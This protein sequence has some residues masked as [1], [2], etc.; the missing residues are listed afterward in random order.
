MEVGGEPGTRGRELG[1]E[2]GK[3]RA[4]S[5]KS[6][7]C[8]GTGSVGICG[9]FTVQAQLAV[10]ICAGESQNELPTLGHESKSPV[11]MFCVRVGE[12]LV[13]RVCFVTKRAPRDRR[14]RERKDP[15][16]EGKEGRECREGSIL[17][18]LNHCRCCVMAILGCDARCAGLCFSTISCRL[19]RIFTLAAATGQ[20]QSGDCRFWSLATAIG[21]QR[22]LPSLE[23]KISLPKSCHSAGILTFVVFWRLV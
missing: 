23:P 10:S 14:Q 8:C 21:H 6:S 12:M 5:E 13:E 2:K 3:K 16:R 7:C 22:F 9:K 15:R 18:V 17:T 19:R 4:K 11:E 20:L 1:S